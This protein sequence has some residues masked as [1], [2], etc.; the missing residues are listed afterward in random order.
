[1]RPLPLLVSEALKD[2]IEHDADARG[3]SINSV[4]VAVLAAKRSIAFV[5]SGRRSS[6][7]RGS[8]SLNLRMPVELWKA[9][10]D[11][12]HEGDTSKQA[13]AVAD[14]CAHYRVPG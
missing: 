8:T 2:A 13:I 14:L 6:G 4:A 9:L 12:A 5:R 1:M 10:H 3:E 11:E 7:H